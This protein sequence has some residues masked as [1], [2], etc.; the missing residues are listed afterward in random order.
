MRSLSIFLFFIALTT[1]TFTACN[2]NP[3]GTSAPAGKAE[4]TT[5]ETGNPKLV[6]IDIDTL[7]T[8][9]DLYIAKKKE[10]EAQSKQEEKALA[11]KIEAFRTRAGR[12]QQ[13]VAA[14]QQKANSLAPVELKKLEEQFAAKQANLAKEEEALY[15]QR[16]NAAMELEK[17]LRASQND[18]NKNID[19][20]LDKYSKEKGYEYILIKGSTGSI[21]Y[22]KKEYDITRDVLK[23]LNEEYKAKTKK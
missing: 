6:H 13:D 4:P 18:I 23:L 20:F 10:I 22:G 7:L 15:S 19:E 9:S 14:I 1:V 21:M 8:Y 12:F 2:S 5:A 16:D 17:K 3:S 11:A